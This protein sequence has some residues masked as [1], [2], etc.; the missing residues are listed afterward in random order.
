[1]HTKECYVTVF[2]YQS[3]FNLPSLS[4]TFA[5]FSHFSFANEIE[6]ITISWMPKTGTV[7]L[8]KLPEVGINWTL[9]KSF[10]AAQHVGLDLKTWGPYKCHPD[11]IE[12]ARKQKQS[13]ESG[14]VRYKA[15][16]WPWRA[17]GKVSNCIHAVTDVLDDHPKARTWLARGFSGSELAL[18]HL[19]K[20]IIDHDMT[21]P[22]IID[23]FFEVK[24]HD[25]DVDLKF[26]AAK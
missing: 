14:T 16:D 4:H 10:H 13:L 8:W 3:R 1:M 6:H 22:H 20:W 24:Q 21:Y 11:L 26:V 17:S 2:G 23:T 15:L 9:Q 5:T 7:N 12:K 18:K 25:I 19:Q